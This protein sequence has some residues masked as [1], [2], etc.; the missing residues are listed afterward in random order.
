MLFSFWRKKTFQTYQFQQNKT[1]TNWGGGNIDKVPF[2]SEELKF[3]V[4]SLSIFSW[5]K[6]KIQMFFVVAIFIILTITTWKSGGV[7]YTAS[8]R[9]LIERAKAW[10]F[11]TGRFLMLIW[12]AKIVLMRCSLCINDHYISTIY[13]LNGVGEQYTTS[14]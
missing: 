4:F 12:L 10:R 11:F 8:L 7:Q 14:R 1:Y 9:A 13:S 2:L 3:G 6:A 5:F